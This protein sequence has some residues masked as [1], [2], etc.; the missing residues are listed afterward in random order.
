MT[1]LNRVV[2]YVILISFSFMVIAPLL[3]LLGAAFSPV[4]SGRIELGDLNYSNFVNVWREAEFGRHLLVSLRLCTLV[5][6]ITL[7]ITTLAAYAIAILNVPGS[8]WIF[9][10]I[11]AGLMIPLESILVPLYFT[12]RAMP[13][14]GGATTLLIAHDC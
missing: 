7:I 6:A 9:T 3:L 10:I 4:Q 11:L 1:R 5:V 2:T 8:K 13:F 12:L 14:G